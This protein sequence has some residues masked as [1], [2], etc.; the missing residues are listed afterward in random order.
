MWEVAYTKTCNLVVLGVI[1]LPRDNNHGGKHFLK[2]ELRYFSSWFTRLKKVVWCWDRGSYSGK[3]V[4]NIPEVTCSFGFG[5]GICF[6]PVLQMW[7]RYREHSCICKSASHLNLFFHHT[8]DWS[9][10]SVH[11]R[12]AVPPIRPAHAWEEVSPIGQSADKGGM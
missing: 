2:C 5:S 11:A 10:K 3:S 1:T 7:W 8:R 12:P 6:H 4:Q 9:F